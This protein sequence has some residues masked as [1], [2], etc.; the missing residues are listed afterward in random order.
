MNRGDLTIAALPGSYGKP[1]PVLII[2]SDVFRHLYSVTV[3]PLSSELLDAP[4]FRITVDPSPENGLLLRSQVLVDKAH[5]LPIHKLGRT[6][7]RLAAG[8]MASV[9]QALSAFLGFE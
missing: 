9:N 3:L 1:R 7:G 6:I 8:D 2:Q 4:D 5:T